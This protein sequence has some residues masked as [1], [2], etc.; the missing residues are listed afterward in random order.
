VLDSGRIVE[1]GSHEELMEKNG[2]YARLYSMQFRN[3]EEELTTLLAKAQADQPVNENLP[4]RSTGFLDILRGKG[5]YNLS[6]V[7]PVK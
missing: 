4:E 1:L 3:P 6:A 2:L 5:R 7:P